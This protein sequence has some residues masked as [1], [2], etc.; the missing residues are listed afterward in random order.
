MDRESWETLQFLLVYKIHYVPNA[1][2][3]GHEMVRLYKKWLEYEKELGKK[4]KKE[5]DELRAKTKV[6]KF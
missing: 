4:Y 3:P 1:D 2:T 5:L 6:K